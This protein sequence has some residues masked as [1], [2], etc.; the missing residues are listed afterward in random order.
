MK[1]ILT[2]VGKTE[3]G[4]NVV[5][6]LFRLFDT[7]GLPLE[8]LFYQYQELNMLPSWTHFYEEARSYGWKH[9]TIIDRLTDSVTDIYGQ[10]F[11]K[12]VLER[13]NTIYESRT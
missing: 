7:R 3:D 1:N 6:G 13:I 5:S 10:E 4:K 2:I 9:K 12:K 11:C 8:V